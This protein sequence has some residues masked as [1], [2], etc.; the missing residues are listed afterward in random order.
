MPP[1]HDVVGSFRDLAVDRPERFRVAIAELAPH[2]PVAQKRGIANDE[3][4]ARPFGA[5]GVDIVQNRTACGVVGNLLSGDRMPLLGDAVPRG[6]RVTVL[7]HGRFDLVIREQRIAML[8]IVK[9]PDDGLGRQRRGAP[10]AEIPLEV[11][12]PQHQVGDGG[13]AGIELDSHQLVRIDC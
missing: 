3:V 4:C 8:N 1:V 2:A 10:R 9:A 12:D 5:P 11:T 13:G 7:V 6:E